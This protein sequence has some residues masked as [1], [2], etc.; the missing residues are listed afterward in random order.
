MGY[1]AQTKAPQS[2]RSLHEIKVTA[3]CMICEKPS[4]VTISPHQLRCFHSRSTTHKRRARRGVKV[5][6]CTSFV[7]CS[8]LDSATALHFPEISIFQRSLHQPVSALPLTARSLTERINNPTTY[9]HAGHSFL[10]TLHSSYVSPKPRP[11]EHHTSL[12]EMQLDKTAVQTKGGTSQD[13]REM[14]RMGKT[15]ELRV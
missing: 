8:S 7:L 6:N 11:M 14:S 1:E 12:E 9:Q 10:Q 15:Q 5:R 2:Y 13:E 3:T 4:R